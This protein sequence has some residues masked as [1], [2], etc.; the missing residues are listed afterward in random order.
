MATVGLKPPNGSPSRTCREEGKGLLRKETFPIL[1]RALA[2]QNKL[3]K[4]RSGV[5]RFYGRCGSRGPIQT[6]ENSGTVVMPQTASAGPRGLSRGGGGGGG[7]CT[8]SPATTTQES[9]RQGSHRW[10]AEPRL[11]GVWPKGKC[12]ALPSLS[13]MCCPQRQYE[14]K[15]KILYGFTSLWSKQ[16]TK[17]T[18]MQRMDGRTDGRSQRRVWRAW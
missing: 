11:E 9:R 14:P 2:Y 12:E 4:T 7:M 3:L 8:T 18:R 15:G 17:Q 16:S 10:E 6:V 1:Y 5:G 13:G